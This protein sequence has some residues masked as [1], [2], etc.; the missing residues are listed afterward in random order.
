MAITAITT[1]SSTS[2]NAGPGDS[3]SGRIQ[4][5]LC[6]R[7]PTGALVLRLAWKHVRNM[8][9]VTSLARLRSNLEIITTH[10]P[11]ICRSSVRFAA[12]L[13]FDLQGTVKLTL[14]SQVLK[15]TMPPRASNFG[16]ELLEK[17]GAILSQFLLEALE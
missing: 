17:D 16:R 1:R 15:N 5:L 10:I 2:V 11:K 4:Q 7:R 14:H 9:L 3:I 12:H 6:P 13:R 8:F